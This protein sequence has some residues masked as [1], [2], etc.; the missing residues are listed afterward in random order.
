[1]GLFKKKQQDDSELNAFLG[2]GTEYRG[3][4]DFVGA[5]RIDGKFEGEISTEGALILGQKASVTGTVRVGHLTSCG[6]IDGEVHVREKATLE[7]TSTLRG[8][9]HTKTLVVEKGAVLEGAV[10]MGSIEQAP[11]T[12][13]VTADFGAKVDEP[14]SEEGAADAEPVAANSA[15]ASI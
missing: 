14:A 15:R 12:N 4:L 7:K 10:S 11:Q 1:M 8:A 3:K 13:V 6:R 5:V 2:V 9:I